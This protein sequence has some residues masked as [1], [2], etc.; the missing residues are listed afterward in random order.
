[1]G[2]G[3]GGKTARSPEERVLPL[4]S[5]MTGR[6]VRWVESRSE[7][8]AAATQSRGEEF[9]VELGGSADGRIEALRMRMRK[10]CGAYPGV[11]ARVPEPYTMPMAGGPYDIAAI[12]ISLDLL[13][14]TL[15]RLERFVALVVHRSSTRSNGPLTPMP[16]KSVSTQ[17]KYDAST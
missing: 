4:L 16:T 14:P 12:D 9:A 1:M 2:G 3:F 7:Y 17:R 5:R 6:P 15:C 13:E 11:G 8:M 10:D